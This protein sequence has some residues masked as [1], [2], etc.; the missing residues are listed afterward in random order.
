MKIGDKSG[1]KGEEG[2]EGGRKGKA[3][4]KRSMKDTI[5]DDCQ[6]PPKS[7]HRLCDATAQPKRDYVLSLQYLFL[8]P[9]VNSEQAVA[10]LS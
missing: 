5:V 8:M 6:W 2:G 9:V 4:G 10:V 1:K 7:T 3:G